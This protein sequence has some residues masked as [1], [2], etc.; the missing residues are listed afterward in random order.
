M[1]ELAP[2]RL[3][4]WNLGVIGGGFAYFSYIDA[5]ITDAAM[6]MFAAAVAISLLSIVFAMFGG[7]AAAP[8]H[9]ARARRFAALLFVAALSLLLLTAT[10]TM[11]LKGTATDDDDTQTAAVSH[12]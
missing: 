5:P 12:A 10:L 11:N 9:A 6:W 4:N 2:H 3:V 1:N 8:T 7:E